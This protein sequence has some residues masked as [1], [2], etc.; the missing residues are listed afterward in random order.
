MVLEM[1]ILILTTWL[2][3]APVQVGG[4]QMMKV[5]EPHHL[6]KAEMRFWGHQNKDPTPPGL[7]QTLLLEKKAWFALSAL[8]H[9]IRLG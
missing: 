3:T 2:Q 8:I 5:I 1:L 4:N 6:Q 7:S 9:S